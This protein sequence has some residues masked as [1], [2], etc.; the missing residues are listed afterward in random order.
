[1]EEITTLLQKV[2]TVTTSDGKNYTGILSGV[3]SHSFNL[4]L[5]DAKDES[6]RLVHKLFLNGNKVAQIFSSEKPFNLQSLADRLERVFPRMVKLSEGAGVIVVM[7]RIRVS[8]KGILEGTG[9]AAER[10]QKVY[11]E[12]IRSQTQ[13]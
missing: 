12:F 3:D 7:D 2:I 5:T 8:E 10:V 13:P 4:C 9:P 11:D 1:M 6:G